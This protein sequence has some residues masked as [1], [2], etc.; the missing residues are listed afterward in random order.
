[1]SIVG[2]ILALRSLE[3]T[4]E[5][6]RTARR[7]ILGALVG[8][9]WS[10]WGWSYPWARLARGVLTTA[11]TESALAPDAVGDDGRSIG[12]L[13]FNDVRADLLDRKDWRLSPFW[14][15]FA[16]A[17]YLRITDGRIATLRP[18]LDG[19]AAWRS[20]WVRGRAL[21]PGDDRDLGPLARIVWRE[22]G[23][24][25]WWLTAIQIGA[26]VLLIVLLPIL[27]IPFAI[28]V[29]AGWLR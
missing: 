15:G 25:F 16:V 13:Q 29:A 28:I 24:R 12:V 9:I 2:D 7:V 11:V 22:I 6:K 1:M 14:S 21:E 4:A 27:A 18:E 17:K 8:A 10:G 19:A 3:A 26:F 20:L 5:R 23:S